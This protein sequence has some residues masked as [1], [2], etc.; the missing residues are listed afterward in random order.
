MNPVLERILSLI[1]Q[2]P[3]GDFVYGEKKKFCEA[4]G[5]SSQ[6]LSDWIAGRSERYMDRLYEIS[7]A[8]GVSV[9]WLRTGEQ[10]EQDELWTE[11]QILRD[12]PDLRGLLKAGK[13]LTPEEV[14]KIQDLVLE[15]KGGL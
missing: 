3:N 1:P 14:R 13:N 5:I 7:E 12:R 11:L 6:N 8:Y 2:K 15:L 9:Q 4:I 10:T